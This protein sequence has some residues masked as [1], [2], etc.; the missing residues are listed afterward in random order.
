MRKLEQAN[1]TDSE[2]WYYWASNYALLGDSNGCIRALRRAVDGGY[3]NYPFML[4]DFYL[5]SMRDDPEFQIILEQAK[6]KHL[7]FKKRFLN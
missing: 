4:T 5:D 2:A 3:F 7:A 6:E 1:I